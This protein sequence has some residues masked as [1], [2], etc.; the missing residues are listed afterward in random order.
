MPPFSV[1][2]EPSRSVR[3]FD[4]F[5]YLL[6]YIISVKAL[7][8]NENRSSYCDSILLQCDRIPWHMTAYRPTLLFHVG[9]FSV[10]RQPYQIYRADRTVSLLR[11]NNLRDTLHL[12]IMIVIIVAVDEHYHVGILLNG[13]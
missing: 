7:C 11:Y 8:Y 5:Y 2:K 4:N 6:T 13:S 10:L 3:L 1:Q 12:G 9:K